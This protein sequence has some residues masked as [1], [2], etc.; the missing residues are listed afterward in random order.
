MFYTESIQYHVHKSGTKL[1][2][3]LV[4][5]S[6]VSIPMMKVAAWLNSIK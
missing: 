5:V 2:E 6:G 3:M 1:G 4:V